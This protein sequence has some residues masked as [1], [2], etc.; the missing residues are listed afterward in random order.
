MR[1]LR[2][3]DEGGAIAIIVAVSSV[4]LFVLAA[5]VVDL[6][7]ARDTRRQS[8]NSAD[9]SALAAA[10]RLYPTAACATLNPSGSNTPPCLSDAVNAAKSYAES[11]Y[12]VTAA[13]WNTCASAPSGYSTVTGS[14][15]C[16]SF[17]D[18]TRPTMVWVQMPTRHLK[19]GLGNAAGVSQ[20]S[21]SAQAR[22]VVDGGIAS[23]CGLCFLGPVD[24]INA[25]FSVEG[26]SIH[27]NGDLNAGPNGIWTA[28]G[29][30]GVVGTV[31][32]GQFPG[33]PPTAVDPIEDPWKD[34]T[35]VPPAVSGSVKSAPACSTSGKKGSS[36]NGPGKYGDFAIPNKACTL[37]PGL[38]V[39]TGAWT[40]KNNTDL[41]GTGVTLYFT[42]GTPGSTHVC[43]PG[44]AGGYLD[45]KNGAVHLSAPTS[46]ATAGLAIVYDR[47]NVSNLGLQ[48]NGDTG[49]TGAVYAPE[50]KARLQRQLVLRVQRGS[51]DR[52][53]SHQGE[54][55]Q[56]V[57][58]GDQLLGRADPAQSDGRRPRSLRSD[59][60]PVRASRLRRLEVGLVASSSTLTSLKVSTLT[61][62][63]NR[64]GRYMSQTQASVIETS[65]NTSPASVRAF[66][67]TWLHR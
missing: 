36:G 20:V 42:C 33:G 3:R 56:V 58:E 15:T 31:S 61:F 8:Q 38:Y 24:A 67:S 50:V 18:L 49:I 21:V 43:N 22:A 9:A 11:N 53:R 65:K 51:R 66:T 55:Q 5:M 60:R 62:L 54:R 10:N 44:E 16:I 23:S 37:D 40:M 1:R 34:A 14:P 47:E 12:G 17:D 41:I 35:N 28:T 7:L 57:R 30:I 48:G 2:S 45:A 29:M 39:I 25:D 27:V 26:G 6:G 46:G 64:A 4:M 59:R 52:H 19:T 13:D 63:A 32:G